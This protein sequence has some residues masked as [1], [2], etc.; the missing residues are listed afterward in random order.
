MFV[1]PEASYLTDSTPLDAVSCSNIVCT[2]HKRA[3]Y[4]PHTERHIDC[5]FPYSMSNPQ[6]TWK[7]L[8]DRALTGAAGSKLSFGPAR[9]M[10]LLAAGILIASFVSVLYH[11]TAV[12]GGVQWLLVIVLGTL[13]LATV[14]AR[15]IGTRSAILLAGLLF[16]GGL[17]VYLTAIPAIYLQLAL[18]VLDRLGTDVL[19]LL[20]GMSV[21]QILKADLWALT[22]APAPIF[23]TWQLA[24][25]RRYELSAGAGS[26]MLGFFTLTGDAGATTT[27]IGMTSAMGLLG[28]GTLDRSNASWEHISDVVLT[29]VIAI[30]ATRLIRII[31]GRDVSTGNIDSASGGPTPTLEGSL[32]RA[33]ERLSILGSISLSSDVRFTVTA[34][35]ASYWHAGAYD[36]YTGGGWIRS[37]DATS[38]SAI[39]SSP[40]GE[41]TTTQQQFH[42]EST[43]GT[44]PAAWKPIRLTEAPPVDVRVTPS[45]DLQ[46]VQSLSNGD[47]YT[48]VSAV[49]EWTADQLR[50]AGTNHPE[51]IRDRYLQVPESTPSRVRRRATQLTANAQTPYEAALLLQQWLTNNKEYSLNVDRPSG[52]IADAFIFKMDRGYCVYYATAMTVMLRTLGI[53]ARFTVGYTPGQRVADDRWVI[54]GYDSHAWVDVYFPEIGWVPFD[55]T[56]AGPRRE[57]EQT[58]LEQARAANDSSADTTETHPRTPTATMTASSESRTGATTSNQSRS[59]PGV[60]Q[61]HPIA[62]G[63]RTD[64]VLPPRRDELVA[65]SSGSVG[66]TSSSVSSNGSEIGGST[67]GGSLLIPASDR[68]R[69][70][71]LASAVG[72][73]LGAY[74]FGLFERGY[75]ALQL[76]WQP[77]TDSPETD[78]VRAF[79]RLERLLAKRYRE[80]RVGEPARA[81]LAALER[82]GIDART[83]R[84]GDLYERAR[85]AGGVSRAEADEAIELV[86][87]LVRTQGILP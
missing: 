8:V 39:L 26:L 33:N 23:L 50:N 31:P 48:V 16:I 27:L 70:T 72:V 19:A 63:R 10:A 43:I 13:A 65:G 24:V 28:F 29:L 71:V 21:I 78:A 69:L 79:E 18:T 46:P 55:P 22:L 80:R 87:D 4:L 36:R 25:R 14:S 30:I 54:R 35:E 64:S 47:M 17:G 82:Q 81:Y 53:P 44:M 3:P 83:H 51:E 66:A 86:D 74:R 59:T 57:A 56:P 9:G 6:S 20:T 58:R 49:P 12:V 34:D 67:A 42:A 2:M 7:T 75:E 45:E 52:N 5:Q 32:I 1:A 60:N 84:V 40:P 85:Y 76:R 73:A 77:R 38:Y 37:G 41:T 68:D 61:S 62:G 11:V 15:F